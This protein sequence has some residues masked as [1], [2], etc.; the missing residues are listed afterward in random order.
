MSLVC[1]AV[2]ACGSPEIKLE[3]TEPV[4]EISSSPVEKPATQVPSTPTPAAQ[5]N[6]EV[7]E[8]PSCKL[9]GGEI[10]EAGWT[11]KDTGSNFCNQCKCMNGNLG[12]TKMAC[13]ARP[14]LT[15]SIPLKRSP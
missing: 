15:A 11:G 4:S 10:V 2:I 7:N 1:L 13:Q 3:G 12:C 5:V 6:G 8:A 9:T 14:T